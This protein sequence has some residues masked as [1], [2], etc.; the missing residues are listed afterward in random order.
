MRDSLNRVSW[1][2]PPGRVY[3][4]SAALCTLEYNVPFLDASSHSGNL[5]QALWSLAAPFDYGRL[6]HSGLLKSSKRLAKAVGNSRKGIYTVL[7]TCV[8]ILGLIE[9]GRQ[10]T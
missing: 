4:H 10:K 2:R 7:K 5:F 1:A 3:T 6:F 8:V 9:A